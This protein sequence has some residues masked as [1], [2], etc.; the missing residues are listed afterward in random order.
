MQQSDIDI[1]ASKLQDLFNTNRE[2]YNV[3]MNSLID[4][5]ELQVYRDTINNIQQCLQEYQSEKCTI[6]DKQEH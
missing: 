2:K 1:V 6:I 4:S 3:V 5:I